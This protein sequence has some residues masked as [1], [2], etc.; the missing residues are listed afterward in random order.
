MGK[1]TLNG[2]R[3][4]I[5]CEGCLFLGP[6]EPAQKIKQINLFLFLYQFD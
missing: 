4:L 6:P 1:F 2:K 5:N 3:S